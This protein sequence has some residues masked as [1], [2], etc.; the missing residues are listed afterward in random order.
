MNCIILVLF[1]LEVRSY[2]RNSTNSS[3]Q[4][5]GNSRVLAFLKSNYYAEMEENFLCPNCNRQIPSINK[6]IHELRC[7]PQAKPVTANLSPG[8]QPISAVPSEP[9]IQGKLLSPA[10]QSVPIAPISF[11]S[12]APERTLP[13]PSAPPAPAALPA[14]NSRQKSG[15][16]C[17]KCTYFNEGTSSHICEVCGTSSLNVIDDSPMPHA[18]VVDDDLFSFPAGEGERAP[19]F[20]VIA[21]NS[22]QCPTCT[23][24]NP[25]HSS[26][27][28][29]CGNPK[30]SQSRPQKQLPPNTWECASCTLINPSSSNNCSACGEIRPALESR[31]ERLIDDNFMEDEFLMFPGMPLPARRSAR[32]EQQQQQQP[33]N[34][35]SSVQSSALLGAGVG[36]GLALL[37]GRS[38]TRGALEGGTMG[39]LG[40][41]LL[42]AMND[43]IEHQQ[44]MP[45]PPH[46]QSRVV[47]RSFGTGGPGG[48][49]ISPFEELAMQ[50]LGPGGMHGQPQRVSE[51]TLHQLPTRIYRASEANNNSNEPEE[52]SICWAPYVD[53]DNVKTLPCL[54]QFHASCIDRWLAVNTACPICKH[55]IH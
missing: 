42:D 29:G 7:L 10:T 12:P 25:E 22:W 34:R 49:Q 4:K 13:L 51:E 43:S 55:N 26:N 53:G 54:H 45:P 33:Q 27:C 14:H 44:R 41:V 48:F 30:A 19:A 38:L 3:I 46:P 47:I 5:Q 39:L 37:N 15:W 21:P 23:L 2:Y 36:A 32:L 35:T 16:T 9:I 31:R 18:I 20:P 40:G 52:C 1:I 17:G 50:I 28:D 11:Q 6:T 24:L 8:V